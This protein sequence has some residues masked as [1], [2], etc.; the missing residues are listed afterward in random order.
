MPYVFSTSLCPY[1]P[2]HLHGKPRGFFNSGS[3]SIW[4]SGF[5]VRVSITGCTATGAAILFSTF[6]MDHLEKNLD[7]V[8]R[9]R[10]R[11]FLTLGS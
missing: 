9:I 11:P 3:G 2:H 7:L 4:I 5:S 1:L 8:G 6:L 10:R